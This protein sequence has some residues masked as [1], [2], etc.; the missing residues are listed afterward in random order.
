VILLTVIRLGNTQSG[1]K[2]LQRVEIRHTF[3]TS[4]IGSDTYV[5]NGAGSRAG[6]VSSCITF[7]LEKHIIPGRHNVVA[8]LFGFPT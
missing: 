3:D 5:G 7:N 1:K 6:P 4:L 8:I 2:S